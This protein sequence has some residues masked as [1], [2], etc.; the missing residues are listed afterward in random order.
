VYRVDSGLARV[1]MVST[2]ARGSRRIP[3]R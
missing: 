1:G 3:S 2:S